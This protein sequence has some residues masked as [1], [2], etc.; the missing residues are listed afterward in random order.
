MT[1]SQLESCDEKK[2]QSNRDLGFDGVTDPA[3]TN[4]KLTRQYI[5]AFAECAKEVTFDVFPAAPL[6]DWA[7]NSPSK[8]LSDIMMVH[9][10]MALGTIHT[11]NTDKAQHRV[12]FKSIASQQ[13]AQFETQYSLQ[14]VHALMFLSFAE[15]A[16]G[17][18]EQGLAY[19]MRSLG[20]ISSLQLNVED[21]LPDK[22]NAYGFSPSM[23]AEC[24]RRTYWA[25]FCKDI[26]IGLTSRRPRFLHNKDVYLRLPCARR[27]Y[28]E[29]EIPD[30]P[31]FD[32][33]NILPLSM[34][35]GNHVQMGHLVYLMQIAFIHS[36]VQLYARR[37]SNSLRVGRSDVGEQ[38][39][40]EMLHARLEDWAQTY[41]AAIRVREKANID[42]ESL[43][44][45]ARNVGKSRAP[46]FAGL[47]ILYH[48]AHMEL[49]RN[50]YHGNLTRQDVLAQASNATQHAV[51]ALK[52]STQLLEFGGPAMRDYQ[53]VIAGPLWGPFSGF[54]IHAAI[55]ILT[56]AGKTRDILEP[57]S[58]I[59]KLLYH[60]LEFIKVT[61]S[62]WEVGE[63]QYEQVKERIQTVYSSAQTAVNQRK[64]YFYCT[65]PM[66][67]ESNKGKEMDLIYGSDRQLYLQV[68]YNRSNVVD[69]SEVFAIDTGGGKQLSPQKP[70]MARNSTKEAG[71]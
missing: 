9:T 69:E 37:C 24:R 64:M 19:H 39:T 6:I 62:E 31:F 70:Y 57:D 21:P 30:A 33:D 45:H 27:L 61:S 51:E 44:D 54:A 15:Y 17:Q 50:L 25:A 59:M 60:G 4:T 36:E 35:T 63:M 26:L 2:N 14:L 3:V 16:D 10:L 42:S 66:L 13:L 46:K 55:D 32:Q 23:F 28:E 67:S 22:S 8:S 53:D 52:M 5:T 29:D 48:W 68:G 7:M 71:E 12:L 38:R 65:E 34:A 58:L 41:T 1:S 56:A 18:H 49:C 43:L 20:V 11:N 40:R 47:D